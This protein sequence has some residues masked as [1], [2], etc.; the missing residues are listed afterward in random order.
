MQSKGELQINPAV[1]MLCVFLSA[2]ICCLLAA[3]KREYLLEGKP[4]GT[5]AVRF[6]L[7]SSDHESINKEK[8]LFFTQ[9]KINC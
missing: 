3:V 2:S 5:T 9:M 6:L 7:D 1:N 8:C 4:D